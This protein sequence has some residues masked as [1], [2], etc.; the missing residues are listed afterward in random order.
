MSIKVDDF[1]VLE[2]VARD[3]TYEERLVIIVYL[4]FHFKMITQEQYLAEITRIGFT[5]ESMGTLIST[6]AEA[7]KK[8]DGQFK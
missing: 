4:Q 5:I 6:K 3:F 2:G 8:Y 7:L 1:P